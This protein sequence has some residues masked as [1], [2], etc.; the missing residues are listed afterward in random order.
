MAKLISITET[1]EAITAEASAYVWEEYNAPRKRVPRARIVEHRFTVSIP[2][3]TE[4]AAPLA[5][6]VEHFPEMV[7]RNLDEYRAGYDQPVRY[8]GGKL[9]T[10]ARMDYRH[11][12]GIGYDY[13]SADPRERIAGIVGLVTSI[14]DYTREEYAEA[15]E[16]HEIRADEYPARYPRA[17]VIA[18][19]VE[20]HAA[21]LVIIGGEVWQQ[22][23]EPAYVYSAPSFFS[24]RPGYVLASV[25]YDSRESN[26]TF[27]AT[28]RVA[29][30]Y[31]HADAARY[32]YIRVLR[33][34]LVTI[35]RTAR[36]LAEEDERK[37]KKAD[38]IRE[39]LERL[40]SEL[41]EAQA[42]ADEARADLDS[43]TA[44]HRAYWSAKIEHIEA[45]GDGTPFKAHR[46][47]RLAVTR[48]E[49][50]KEA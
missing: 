22:C 11:R 23:K 44:D 30:A 20:R 5:F 33:P 32:A 27:G 2:K 31:Y 10:P 26:W 25:D 41:A 36:E 38:E 12:H 4:E 16:R 35:D 13:E 14:S 1:A 37:R 15:I 39:K 28:D 21:N 43:Y 8:A 40:Q 18:Q 48:R 29:L 34:D 45:V 47:R 6:V 3:Y 49:L 50:N 17:D 9:Y 7:G 19:Y 46:A 24:R 42:E